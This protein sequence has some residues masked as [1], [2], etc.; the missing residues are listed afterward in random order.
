[1]AIP[2]GTLFLGGGN[3]AG[4]FAAEFDRIVSADPPLKDSAFGGSLAVVSGEGSVSYERPALS[5]AY[6][7]PGTPA[8]LPGFHSCVGGGGERQEL[9]WY[10]SKGIDYRLGAEA[11]TVDVSGRTVTLSDGSLLKYTNLVIATGCRPVDL[12][13]DFKMPGAVEGGGEGGNVFYLRDVA[14]ADKLYSALEKAASE[15]ASGSASGSSSE[16]RPLVIGGGYIGEKRRERDEERERRKRKTFFSSF[17][18]MQP[19]NP[20]KTIT[21]LELAAALANFGLKPVVAFPEDRILARILTPEAAA[22][23]TK[24][25]ELKGAELRP[26]VTVKALETSKDGAAA[27]NV[28]SAAALSDGSSL[29]VSLVVVGV[30]ARP[31]TELFEK[32]S[33]IAVVEGAPGGVLVDARLRSVSAQNVWACGDVAAFP[34]SCL[35]GSGSKEGEKG[36]EPT[37]QEHVQHARS[38]AAFVARDLVARSSS[39]SEPGSDSSPSYSYL[40]YYYS[41]VFDL[42]WV[43]Y[44][45]SSDATESVEFGERDAEAAALRGEKQTFGSFHLLEVEAEADGG[46]GAGKKE[47]RIVGAFLEG[48]SPEQN[49]MVRKLVEARAVVEE[50]SAPLGIE[51]ASAAAAKL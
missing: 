12:A 43:F 47:K 30:G 38:S 48:G 29:P 19:L 7:A 15:A 1:M 8:R 6:L 22:F 13:K 44:G 34:S 41:R 23:Y 11:T 32:E 14:D 40:P 9:S 26:G 4:Y 36:A 10:E 24:F 50:G 37:R 33:G 51:W 45:S 17:L 28:V 25:Y 27:S 18:L 42:G 21:G 31:R 39:A 3:A 16:A 20:K 49:A 46:S 5:K 2:V 35:F